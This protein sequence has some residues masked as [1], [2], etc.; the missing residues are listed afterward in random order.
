MS[1]VRQMRG[2]KDYD[3]QWNTRMRGTGPYAEMIARRFQ[4]AAKRYGFNQSVAAT[5]CDEIQEAAASRRATGSAVNI[6]AR[7]A[8]VEDHRDMAETKKRLPQAMRPSGRVG[9]IFGWLMGRLN[10][11]SYLWTIEQLRAVQPKS[12]LEIGFG[13]GHLLALAAKTFKPE[14]LTGVDLSELMVETAQKRLHK[15][16]KKT[17]LDIRQGDDT[18][19]PDGPFDAI[20]ALHS[21]QFWSDPY[22]TLARVRAR[23]SP[24]GRFIL[25]L[26]VHTKRSGR[27]VPN[28]LSRSGNEIAAACAALERA[29]FSV[30][31]MGGISKSSQGIVAV[32]R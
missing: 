9:R 14:R 28:P 23:L 7:V 21:F 12:V 13:T 17:T 15:Y 1:L 22:A 30:T 10:R 11:D 8:I 3:S 27:N 2:G 20:M 25:V 18:S 26:R 16:R 6:L 4:L 19:L 31:G 29:D 5:G 32:P 24:G